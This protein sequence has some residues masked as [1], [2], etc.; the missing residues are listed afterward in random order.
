M[1]ALASENSWTIRWSARRQG[2]RRDAL[3]V[4]LQKCGQDELIVEHATAYRG[5]DMQMTSKRIKSA[6]GCNHA[7][8]AAGK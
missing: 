1:R 6:A 7:G 4:F 5:N 8:E 3:F 2:R